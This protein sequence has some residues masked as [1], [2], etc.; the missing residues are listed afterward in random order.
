MIKI[1]QIIIYNN[2]ILIYLIIKYIIYLKY[3]KFK[4]FRL[5]SYKFIKLQI[6]LFI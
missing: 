2:F 5:N 4:I 3:N 6:I 1:Y